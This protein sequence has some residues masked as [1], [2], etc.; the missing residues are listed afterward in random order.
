MPI[1]ALPQAPYRQDRKIFPT[2]LVTDV[3]FSEVRDCT[4]SEFPEY[5][6]PHPNANKWPHHK[7]VFIKPVDIERNE[8]FEFFYAAERQN[9]DLYNFSSGYRNVIGNTG[10][11][12]FRVVQRSY[13]TLREGFQP[14]DIPFGVAMPDIP[15]GKFEGVEYV[16]FDRQ[17]QPIPEQELNALFV[18]EIHTYIE[19]AFLEYKLSYGTQKSEVIPEKFRALIPQ[20]ST[21][22]LVAG[23]VE[24]PTLTGS[25]LSITQ[26]QIN[27]DIKLV[28]AT[29]RADQQTGYS[30]NGKQVTNVLQIADV[31]ETIVPEGTTI[32]AT[33]LT[34]DGSVEPLGNGQSIRRVITVPELFAAKT[35]AAERPDVVPEKFR[36]A[37][38]TTTTEERIEGIAIGPTLGVSDLD[39][40]EQQENQFVKRVKKTKRDATN[41]PVALTQRAT[42]NNKQIATVTE[43][44]QLGDATENPSATVDIESQALGDGTYVVRK[45]RVPELFAAKTFAAERPDVVP[46]K[47]RAVVPTTTT[48]ERIEGIAIGPTLGVSDLDAVE[49]QENQFVKRVKKTKRDATNLPV[50][51]TQRATSNNK[52]IATVTETLQ[53]GDATEKPSATVDIESQALGDGTYVVRKVQVPELF[54][55]KAF[56]IQR[57]DA[58][59]EKFRVALPVAT[60]STNIIGLV[61]KPTLETGEIQRSVEQSNE[62]VYR[63]QVTKRDLAEASVLT[64]ERAYVEG[65]PTADVVETYAKNQIDIDTGVHV[66]QSAVSPLGDGSFIKETVSVKSWP[67][68]KGS[69][70]DSVLNAQV[71][72]TQQM[73]TPPSAT[74]FLAPNTSYRPINEDR[75]LK[76][77]EEA[78]LDALEEYHI[79][80]PTRIDLKLPAVL[81][82]IN[83][84]WVVDES[85][86]KGDSVGRADNPDNSRVYKINAS[87]GMDGKAE[88]SAQPIVSTETE[89]VF[90]NDIPA[91]VHFFYLSSAVQ[92]VSEAAL[93]SR[94]A[95]LTNSS[96][97]RWPTFK[98]KSHTIIAN[99]AQV[100]AV[101]NARVE[102]AISKDEN[103]KIIAQSESEGGSHTVNRSI[104]VINL[105]PTI[106]AAIAVEGGSSF[107]NI[108]ATATSRARLDGDEFKDVDP[109]I[110]SYSAAANVSVFPLSFPATSPP[111]IPRAGNYLVSSSAEPFKWGWV[112]CSATIINASQFSS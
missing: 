25:Q 106:H 66:V 74:D 90:G 40:V 98:P 51:L 67:V 38:P 91:T 56:N 29:S 20:T 102:A 61:S 104:D 79:S 34:V 92:P 30:L 112:K 108:R 48:E 39:A 111:D 78:P 16:F 9:Q 94:I 28:R 32:T 17:Q 8:V 14:L 82:S 13:V 101:S 76:I 44:L 11:R 31:V 97:E 88:Y 99:G 69:E 5:G 35:F 15:E 73:V 65:G 72:N 1:S 86:G 63:E 107:T 68:L 109:V 110:E 93:I 103:G 42:S 50:A 80:V 85:V 49:Q 81:R 24:Q 87:S 19:T 105:A 41:L 21:E 75:S 6:T 46:E 3:L 2:P 45:V 43:T 52:Q 96:V 55:A 4:R 84:L 37:L 95:T 47:F 70:F 23:L 26:D 60:E 64:G 58:T 53:I 77:V 33:A 10:G 62:F 54:E 36:V 100:S 59:P 83:V 18:A 57:P 27:P 12:E 22:Q 7:L 71:V 89:V